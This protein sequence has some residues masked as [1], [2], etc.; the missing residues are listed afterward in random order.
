MSDLYKCVITPN[1]RTM[2]MRSINVTLGPGTHCIQSLSRDKRGR[3]R[4]KETLLPGGFIVKGDV[5]K[6]QRKKRQKGC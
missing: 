6:P 1:V 3:W 5:N 2:E 4:V